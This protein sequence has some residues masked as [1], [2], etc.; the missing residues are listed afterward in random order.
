MPFAFVATGMRCVLSESCGAR[1]VH[2]QVASALL[3][4]CQ[5]VGCGEL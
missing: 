5:E 3:E 2:G 1:D 4:V